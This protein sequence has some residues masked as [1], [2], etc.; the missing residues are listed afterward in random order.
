MLAGGVRRQQP[1]DEG[2]AQRDRLQGGAHDLEWAG[3]EREPGHR[4]AAVA[5]P[6]G[7]PLAGQERQ[8]G[9]PVGVGGHR[10]QP[11]LQRRVV[12]QP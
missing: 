7:R 9:E 4:A 3:V 12:G 5:A 2:Q 6:A 10:L 11:L 8:H 1:V